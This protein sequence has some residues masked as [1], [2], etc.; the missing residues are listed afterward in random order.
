MVAAHHE[1]NLEEVAYADTPSKINRKCT[2]PG[3]E[4]STIPFITEKG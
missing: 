1:E 3:L 2:N 4:H